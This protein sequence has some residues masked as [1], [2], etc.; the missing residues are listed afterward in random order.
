MISEGKQSRPATRSGILCLE[1]WKSERMKLLFLICISTYSTLHRKILTH[2]LTFC[3]SVGA[4]CVVSFLAFS[5]LQRWPVIPSAKAASFILVEVSSSSFLLTFASSRLDFSC[6][7]SSMN[8][9]HVLSNLSLLVGEETSLV[10]LPLYSMLTRFG[11]RYSDCLCPTL[12]TFFVQ[13]I[14]HVTAVLTLFDTS[15]LFTLR[16][17]YRKIMFKTGL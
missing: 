5:M 17:S 4:N 8:L 10:F 2:W 1:F 9:S 13:E 12:R 15:L 11:T 16:Y 3:H 7:F 6:F 14:L